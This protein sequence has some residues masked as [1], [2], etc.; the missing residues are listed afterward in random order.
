MTQLS[1]FK[2]QNCDWC[3]KDPGADP[4]NGYFWNGIR[5]MQTGMRICFKCRPDFYKNNKTKPITDECKN[6]H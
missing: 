1:L 4:R 2:P 6:H 3:L 5:D